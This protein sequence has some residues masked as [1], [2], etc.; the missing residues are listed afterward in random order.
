MKKSQKMQQLEVNFVPKSLHAGLPL[1]ANVI[2]DILL[3][4]FV[5]FYFKFIILVISKHWTS[6]AIRRKIK[7]FDFKW[8]NAK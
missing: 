6:F 7:M 2:I 5:I 4:I 3:W 1:W 8:M